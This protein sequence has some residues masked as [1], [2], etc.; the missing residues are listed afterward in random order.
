MK[1][2]NAMF[3]CGRGG[4]EQALV[5]S[6]EALKL[7]GHE[8]VAI[9]HPKAAIREE[10]QTRNV[11]FHAL[12]N[13][14]AWDAIAMLKLRRLL[15]R[16]APHA[17]I[18]HGNRAVSL[19]HKANALRIV[20]V[21]HN[22]KI[23]TDPLR[24][25]FYPTQDLLRHALAGGAAGKQFFHV[26]N[27]VRVPAQFT[28]RTW[29]APPVIGAMGRFVTKKGFD[30][31]IE[32]LALLKARGVAFNAVLAGDGEEAGH[33]KKLA[34]DK[35]LERVLR[36]PGWVE[37]RES[38]L[39]GI[40]LFCMPS[41]HEPFGIVLL[42]AMAHGLPVVATASEGPSEILTGGTDG[43]LVK[44]GD[45]AALADALAELLADRPRAELLARNAWQTV[46]TRY[47]LPVVAAK[48]DLALRAICAL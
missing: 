3:G 12:S 38:F 11:P 33:L 22:Y 45:A 1:I 46:K 14:G 29:R 16:L 17:S 48:L 13:F 27:L 8:P 32:A 35:G 28:P 24:F 37:Y 4:I 6:C 23:K 5:D 36:F 44:K 41:H 9:I 7:C 2:I 10:L 43:M 42:E 25:V 18:A 26:P 19:L 31:F 15:A 40:D 39:D 47:D 20:G 30:L 34:A 21:M